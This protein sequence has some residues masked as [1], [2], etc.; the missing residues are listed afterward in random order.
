MTVP[1]REAITLSD[2]SFS[3]DTVFTLSA[4]LKR[5]QDTEKPA[6]FTA[7]VYKNPTTEQLYPGL[8]AAFYKI[9]EKKVADPETLEMVTSYDR[10]PFP[11]YSDLFFIDKVAY[12]I[13]PTAQ[14]SISGTSILETSDMVCST[15][16][17]Q[18]GSAGICVERIQQ[19]VGIDVESRT[20]IF[21]SNT[22]IKVKEFQTANSLTSNG[23]VGPETWAKIEEQGLTN[24]FGPI[25]DIRAS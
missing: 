19:A 2:G 16:T 17:F 1:G 4:N 21:D 25:T 12:G 5:S 15:E 13:G 7:T 18:S 8:G 10:V 11:T 23:I 9:K 20:G 24:V 3:T 14:V 6:T 22:E